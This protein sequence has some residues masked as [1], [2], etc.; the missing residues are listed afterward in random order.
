MS[1]KPSPS[2][3]CLRCNNPLPVSRGG[4][5]RVWCSQRC[6][7]AAYEERRAAASGAIAVRVVEVESEAPQHTLDDC[8]AAVVASSTACRR[9]IDALAVAARRG[10]LTSDPRWDPTLRSLARLLEALSPPGRRH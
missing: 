9:V 5:P 6:R 3:R 2:G 4:R 7:R 8:V 1:D 10:E